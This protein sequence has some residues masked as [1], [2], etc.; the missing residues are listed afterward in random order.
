MSELE[1]VGGWSDE[2]GGTA[3]VLAWKEEDIFGTKK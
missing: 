3:S 2:A 1:S